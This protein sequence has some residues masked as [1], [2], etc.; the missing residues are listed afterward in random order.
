MNREEARF[1]KTIEIIEIESDHLAQFEALAMCSCPEIAQD[2]YHRPPDEMINIKQSD[3]IREIQAVVANQFLLSAQDL[4]QYIET[5]VHPAAA[6]L[7]RDPQNALVLG[8]GDGLIAREI[9]RY[10]SV[11]NVTIVDVRS[12]VTEVW[13]TQPAAREL[14]GDVLRDSRV[15]VVNELVE[16]WMEK[17]ATTYDLIA[18]DLVCESLLPNQVFYE[19]LGK[20]A[21]DTGVVSAQAAFPAGCGNHLAASGVELVPAISKA[22]RTAGL[23]AQMGHLGLCSLCN[24]ELGNFVVATK[25]I[26]FAST[27]SFRWL[28]GLK[29]LNSTTFSDLFHERSSR[30]GR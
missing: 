30:G 15:T 20:A 3:L 9:L 21:G 18:I 27:P 17:N 7:G 24:T 16:S 25:K 12:P 10:G 11:K 5:L 13:A 6:I 4:P 1:D 22:F 14:N 8:G 19:S 26:S 29:Y 2:I 28:P 23:D